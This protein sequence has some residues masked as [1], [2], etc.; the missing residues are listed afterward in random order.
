MLASDTVPQQPVAWFLLQS[1]K[2]LSPSSGSV[3]VP[4][5]IIPPSDPVILPENVTAETMD[6]RL[7]PTRVQVCEEGALLQQSI[8]HP[9]M[10]GPSKYLQCGQI[11]LPS[12]LSSVF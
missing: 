5:C 8:H 4:S 9:Y 10:W 7:Q 1:L 2:A 12:S 11:S 3:C 6:H